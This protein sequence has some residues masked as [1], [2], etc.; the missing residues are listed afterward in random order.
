M[1]RIANSSYWI[2]IGTSCYSSSQG[3]LILEVGMGA[4]MGNGMLVRFRLPV[5]LPQFSRCLRVLMIWEIC[6]LALSNAQW[7]FAHGTAES[8][9]GV[10]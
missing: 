1:V 6:P 4:G 5:P 8:K 10:G 2:N 3:N 7:R 9:G